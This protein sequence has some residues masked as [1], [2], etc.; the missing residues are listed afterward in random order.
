MIGIV[1]TWASWVL[2]A[3]IAV[4]ALM[5]WHTLGTLVATVLDDDLSPRPTKR[6]RALIE[7]RSLRWAG[8][9]LISVG[10]YLLPTSSCVGPLGMGVLMACFPALNNPNLVLMWL[11]RGDHEEPIG[12]KD[13]W[14]RSNPQ[15]ARQYETPIG[16]PTL[17]QWL[18]EP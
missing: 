12:P 7:R 11:P 4:C 3:P 8:G 18:E 10:V 9:F 6:V 16:P 13:S 1:P 15:P 14:F 17:G 5:A 2:M